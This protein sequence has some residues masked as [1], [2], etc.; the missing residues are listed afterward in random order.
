MIKQ[1]LVRGVRNSFKKKLMKSGI[2]IKTFF[3][4]VHAKKA[5]T[6]G[7]YWEPS[8]GDLKGQFIAD[9]WLTKIFL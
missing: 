6:R 8:G 1:G 4:Q 3:D 2:L 9:V 5:S 7:G